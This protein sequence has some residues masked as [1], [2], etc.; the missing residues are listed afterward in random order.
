MNVP[1]G[2]YKTDKNNKPI[3]RRTKVIYTD[4]KFAFASYT[5]LLQLT[6]MLPSKIKSVG[7]ACSIKIGDTAYILTCAHNVSTYSAYKKEYALFKSMFAYR[8]R[9]GEKSWYEYSSVDNKAS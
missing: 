4:P 1:E 8:A 7:S 3:D 9:Q 6:S 5:S 2:L